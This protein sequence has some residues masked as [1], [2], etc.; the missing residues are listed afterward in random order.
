MLSTYALA[1]SQEI[2]LSSEK[3]FE[4]L[5][6]NACLCVDSIDTFDKHKE[7]VNQEINTCIDEATV[8][9]QMGS[10]LMDIGD[11]EDLE[12]NSDTIEVNIDIN[13]DKNSEEYKKY[14]YELERYMMDSCS[15]LKDKVNNYEKLSEHS[16]SEN[17][18]AI[19]YYTKGL[20]E[21]QEEN[22]EE[23]VDYFQK[24]VNEDPQFAFAWDNLGLSYRKLDEFDEAIE[25]YET[26]LEID[27]YGKMPLQNIAV[28]YQY[29][30]EYKKAIKAYKRLGE[31][32]K[33]NPEI[34]YGMGHVYVVNL[35]D[36]EKGL[37]NMCKAYNIYVEQKSPYRADA[38]KMINHIYS[39]MKK[40]GNEEKFNEILEDNNISA[41]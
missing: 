5:A 12:G 3:L 39:E 19:D 6:D 37:D 11:L 35:Q 28:A 30:E 15:S 17:E 8:A 21:M 31:I 2:D 10:K 20:D 16:L 34:Y 23:A 36:Y 27:P 9:Y 14:Y 38:E 40:Q 18:K 32:D 24:A 13:I 7:E 22:Y 33:E 26:S 25:A 29:K 4:E 1:I 41:N